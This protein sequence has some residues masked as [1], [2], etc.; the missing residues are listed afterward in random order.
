M[1]RVVEN[2]NQLHRSMARRASR[3]QMVNVRG[4]KS[5]TE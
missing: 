1:L 5:S 3:R 2:V 4:H